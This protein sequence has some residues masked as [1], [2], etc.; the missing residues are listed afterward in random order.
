MKQLLKRA[1]EVT[2]NASI[3][4][5]QQLHGRSQEF[6][7]QRLEQIDA[8]GHVHRLALQQFQS[9]KTGAQDPGKADMV[10]RQVVLQFHRKAVLA[11]P[12]ECVEQ[13]YFR[14]PPLLERPSLEDGVAQ[15]C[16]ELGCLAAFKEPFNG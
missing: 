3:I 5:L 8:P 16:R 2:E 10:L 14:V 15:Q 4:L 13:I 7:K 11:V 6:Q 1:A 9:L 12:V